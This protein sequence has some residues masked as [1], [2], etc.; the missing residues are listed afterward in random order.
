MALILTL[1]KPKKLVITRAI[2][3]DLN[4]GSMA[5][6]FGKYDFI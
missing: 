6:F 5:L 3:Y 1:R 2:S 4:L